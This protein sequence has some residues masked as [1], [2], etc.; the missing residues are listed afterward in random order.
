M[1]LFSPIAYTIAIGALCALCCIYVLWACII[2]E[3]K[4]LNNSGISLIMAECV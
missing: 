1:I 4:C 3:K 2:I